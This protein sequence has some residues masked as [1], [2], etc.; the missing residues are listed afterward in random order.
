MYGESE[1]SP[2]DDTYGLK[3]RVTRSIIGQLLLI[4]TPGTN[5]W[6]EMILSLRPVLCKELSSHQ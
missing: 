5:S 2:H 4:K 6:L 3:Y 1:L